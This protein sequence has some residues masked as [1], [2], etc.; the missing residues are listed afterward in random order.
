MTTSQPQYT[1]KAASDK[2]IRGSLGPWCPTIKINP[3]WS[4]P[5][6]STTH[7]AWASF[8]VWSAMIL[9]T[10]CYY[11]LYQHEGFK[12]WYWIIELQCRWM[13]DRAT[14]V[15][16]VQRWMIHNY[17]EVRKSEVCWIA[18]FVRHKLVEPEIHGAV[19]GSPRYW[20]VCDFKVVERCLTNLVPACTFGWLCSRSSPWLNFTWPMSIRLGEDCIE[21]KDYMRWQDTQRRTKQ[22][23][24]ILSCSQGAMVE[25]HFT[26]PNPI[27]SMSWLRSLR[28]SLG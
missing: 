5:S 20:Y 4:C 9:E 12:A 18:W 7:L 22:K 16:T 24:V 25:D 1:H 21:L 6:P 13:A 23:L 3:I 8:R 27:Y 14:G 28:T 15:R 19:L 26:H 11:S 17:L 2:W 10:F